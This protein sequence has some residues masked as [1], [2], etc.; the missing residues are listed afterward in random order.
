MAGTVRVRGGTT[1]N[2]ESAFGVSPLSASVALTADEFVVLTVAQQK[3]GST[4]APSVAAPTHV[5]AW[6]SIYDQT[7]TRGADEGR[8]TVYTGRVISTTAAETISV[9]LPTLPDH[10]VWNVLRFSDSSG[11]LVEVRNQDGEVA[12]DR[13]GTYYWT[14]FPAFAN[15][16]GVLA[17]GPGGFSYHS[18]TD[19][20]GFFTA[21]LI[22][23]HDV[24]VASIST[25]NW[26]YEI[27][28]A[29]S[30]SKLQVNTS[31]GPGVG[32]EAY[33]GLYSDFGNTFSASGVALEIGVPPIPESFGG[34][35][36]EFKKRRASVKALPY[37]L[38]LGLLDRRL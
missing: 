8:T 19:S 36:A 9:A 30:G 23:S 28:S 31:V 27:E 29:G 22:D 3:A 24:N 16:P 4:A 2:L 5:D 15:D 12:S 35:A 6:T 26:E 33:P 7:F 21:G 1:K 37:Y 11:D 20:I 17:S 14:S 18:A 13:T 10:A 34:G 25:I 38:D 32:Q